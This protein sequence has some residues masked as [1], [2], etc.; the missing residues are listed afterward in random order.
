M[1]YNTSAKSLYSSILFLFFAIASFSQTHVDTLRKKLFQ[2]GDDYVFVVAHR[3]DWRNA[4]ENSIQAI[5][6]CIAMGADIVE[7]DVQLSKDSVL[8]LLHDKTLNRT[9]NGKGLV[10]D[11]TLAELKN[12]RLKDG[13]GATL[14]QQQIPTL[15]EA[16]ELCKG[17]ILVNVDKAE[18]YM[19]LVQQVVRDVGFEEGVLYKGGRSY[20]R[21]HTQYGR[22]LDDIV[23]MPIISGS[24]K[25]IGTFVADFI[26]KYKPM[27]FEVVFSTEDS[28]ALRQ[29]DRIKASGARV[30]M[31]SLWP[32]LNAGHD[33]E[34]AVY[35]PDD[36]WGWLLA[37]GATIIQTDRPLELIRY[38][39]RRGLR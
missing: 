30:W 16:M 24:T 27:A 15:R 32:R 18:N 21:L 4:P 39:E 13:A 26:E 10:S 2:E 36:A 1:K 19:D 14:Q 34:R 28:P 9:T 17:R 7:L 29:V 35:E 38:L 31:N 12:L 3:G 33:D 5:E 6:R 22:L 37:R 8:V 20:E 25:E 23:Y 11:Y